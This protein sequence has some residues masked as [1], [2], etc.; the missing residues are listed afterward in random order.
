[1][2]DRPKCAERVW[3]TNSWGSVPCSRYALPGQKYCKQHSPEAKA[4]RDRVSRE[5]YEAKRQ[6]EAEV[7][8]RRAV[9]LLRELGYTVIAPGTSGGDADA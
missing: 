9:V 2:G 5:R 6:R 7:R 1:M 4:E 3:H 8:E